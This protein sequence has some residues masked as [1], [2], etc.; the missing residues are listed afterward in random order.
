MESFRF[1]DNF[2]FALFMRT[3]KLRCLP[4]LRLWNYEKKQSVIGSSLLARL[5]EAW[6]LEPI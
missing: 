1:I 4:S 5:F 3:Y 6:D 2:S